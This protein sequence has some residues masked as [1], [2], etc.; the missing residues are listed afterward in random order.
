MLILSEGRTGGL[1]GGYGDTNAYFGEG[2]PGG[3][4]GYNETIAYSEERV[5]KPN[6]GR[7]SETTAA[8][9]STT[10][11]ESEL[12]YKKEEKH[13]KHLK[14]LGKIGVAA[15]GAF[16]L[17]EKHNEKKDPE[18]AHMHKIEE[19]IVAA[20]AVGSGGFAF[21]E[22]H[23]KKKD[24]GRIGRGSWKEEAPPLLDLCGL[25]NIIF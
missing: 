25:W 13:H 15:A 16:A 12:D 11:H 7:Y 22:H 14:H 18:H 24:K 19:E 17:H 4:N 9:G 2:R 8:Y 21:H 3:Y 6:G 23:E 20:A 5:E 1:G 10:A